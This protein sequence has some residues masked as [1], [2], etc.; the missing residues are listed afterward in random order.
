MMALSTTAK[1]ALVMAGAG[2]ALVALVI[3]VARRGLITVRYALGWIFIGLL[4][5]IGSLFAGLVPGLGE[6]AGMSPTAVLL[7]GAV[8]VLVGIAIQ[9]SISVSGLQRQLRDVIER[10]ALNNASQ[11]KD[12]G[13]A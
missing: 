4:V 7:V 12:G 10:E 3:L 9:L 8:V 6:V 5:I 11:T 13:P 2:L 1:Q